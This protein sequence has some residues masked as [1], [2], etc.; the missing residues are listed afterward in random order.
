MKNKYIKLKARYIS[1][2]GSIQTYF[3]YDVGFNLTQPIYDIMYKSKW[4]NLVLF[5][6]Q[7]EE[8]HEI[9]KYCRNIIKL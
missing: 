9:Y 2:N 3:L 5:Y 6:I 4:K 1:G 7:N 8:E